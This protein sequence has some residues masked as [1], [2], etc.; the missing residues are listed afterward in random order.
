MFSSDVTNN[1]SFKFSWAEMEGAWIKSDYVSI[2]LLTYAKP[3]VPSLQIR[4]AITSDQNVSFHFNKVL[5]T[6][7]KKSKN[8]FVVILSHLWSWEKY[9]SLF[10]DFGY[11]TVN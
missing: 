6:Y 8:H 1:I 7:Y 9:R 11:G 2:F 3:S 4:A 10:S 5:L